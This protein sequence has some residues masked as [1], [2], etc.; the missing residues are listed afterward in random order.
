MNRE[1][2]WNHI[3]FQ[4][5]M[6][7]NEV[8]SDFLSRTPRMEW[9]G[10]VLPGVAMVAFTHAQSNAIMSYFAERNDRDELLLYEG[11]E[12][13]VREI[14][15]ENDPEKVSVYKYSIINMTDVWAGVEFLEEF[16]SSSA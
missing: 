12:H 7:M 11:N 1:K 16:E 8:T 3:C 4:G 15:N 6:S 9:G 2:T 5:F 13:E 14:L 10:K